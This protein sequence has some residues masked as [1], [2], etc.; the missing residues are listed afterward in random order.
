MQVNRT[1]YL[2]FAVF[3][4]GGLVMIGLGL[5]LPDFAGFTFL[6]IGGIWFLVTLIL[7]GYAIRSAFKARHDQW[8]FKNGVRGKGTLVAAW[9]GV[10]VN[11]QPH[12]TLELDVDIPGQTPR[13]VKR[14]MIVSRFAAQRFHKGMVLPVYVHPQDPED[15]LVVW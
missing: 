4:G 1:G 9:S 11:E 14:S 7:I 15:I 10:I 2:L 8:L 13:R 6:L 12:M 5:L 3:G